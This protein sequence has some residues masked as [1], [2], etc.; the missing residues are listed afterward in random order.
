MN[1]PEMFDDDL[2]H[3]QTTSDNRILQ[4]KLE[5]SIEKYFDQACDSHIKLLLSKCEWYITINAKAIVLTIECPDPI[6]NWH[7]LQN[8]VKIGSVLE[9]LESAKIR[10]CPPPATGT[11]FEMRVKEIFVYRESL[12]S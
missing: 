9:N 2:S 8:L 6:T 3:S 5:N 7:I 1:H 10:V 4:R 11:P 12:S